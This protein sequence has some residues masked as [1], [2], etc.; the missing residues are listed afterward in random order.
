MRELRKLAAFAARD[1]HVQSSYRF[2]VLVNLGQMLFTVASFFFIGRLVTP[3]RAASLAPYGGDYFAFVLVGLA[4]SQYLSTSLS[5]FSGAI[6][7]EQLQGTL[8]AI[9]ATPT[10]LST[11]MLGGVLWDF[12]WTTVEV[13][14]CLGLGVMVF[15][16]DLGR[17]N[18]PAS[19][20]LWG[21]SLLSLSS[22]GVLSACGILL[23]KEADPIS[24]SLGGVMKLLGG[25]YFPIVLLPDWLAPLAKLS[26][27]TYVL[28]GIRQAVLVGAPLH[29]L[30]RICALLGGCALVLWPLAM[31]SFAWTMTRLKT[32]GALSFR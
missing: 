29:E 2:A 9:L 28:E 32:T 25:V 30:W 4:G 26:P 3:Q 11:I 22:L 24:W 12:F 7:D 19:V 21:L 6:R 17:I 20:V 16:V 1:W 18:V 8:E 14:V 13:L 27:L 31:V 5:S 23:F 10:R 15:G